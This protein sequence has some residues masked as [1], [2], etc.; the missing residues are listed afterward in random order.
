LLD[1]RVEQVWS[2]L[3]R[4]FLD[5]AAPAKAR[6]A[7]QTLKQGQNDF[8]VHY[9]KFQLL[10]SQ[11]DM[12][13]TA[14]YLKIEAFQNTLAGDL[15]RAM[16]GSQSSS[17]RETFESFVSRARHTWEELQIVSRITQKNPRYQATVEPALETDPDA[18]DTSVGAVQHLHSSSRSSRTNHPKGEYWG[19][20][21]TL[22]K[23]KR[24]GLCLRCGHRSHFVKHCRVEDIPK[25]Q[26]STNAAPVT[27]E[28]D[29]AGK[30]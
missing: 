29:Q 9:Q 22:E 24:E 15:L 5:P 1:V 26:Q 20:K 25:Q 7:I 28:S 30:A 13:K 19:S 6:A 11:A 21:E 18:M 8:N 10:L 12:N 4:F 17:D 2:V 14:D 3:D 16:I 27:I 23:R